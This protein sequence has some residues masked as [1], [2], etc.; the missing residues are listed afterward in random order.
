MFTA[1]KESRLLDASVEIGES[2]RGP[3]NFQS[4][5]AE[6]SGCSPGRA[7]QWTY[8]DRRSDGES[9]SLRLKGASQNLR[10]SLRLQFFLL[11]GHQW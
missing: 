3:Q 9:M 6:Y 1:T 10:D 7:A 8:R 2:P 5:A 11:R 4:N